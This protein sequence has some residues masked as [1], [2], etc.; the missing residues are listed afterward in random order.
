MVKHNLKVNDDNN[1]KMEGVFLD[2]IMCSM[3]LGA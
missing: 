2:I 3:V 1:L